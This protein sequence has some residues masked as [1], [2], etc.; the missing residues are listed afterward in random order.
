M[1][2]GAWTSSAFNTYTTSTRG[3]DSTTYAF[4]SN[5]NVQETFK[6]RHLHPDM[7]PRNVVRECLDTAEH[8]NTVPVILA[9]DVTGSMGKA[10]TEVSRKLG[11]IMEA[12]YASGK[13]PDVEFCVMAIGDLYCDRAPVQISQFESDI[14]IAEHLDKIWF[15]GG[16]GG[17]AFESYT[18]AW[19]MGLDHC[20]LDCWKRGRR[21]IIITMGDEQMNPYLQKDELH[22]FIGDS[23]QDDVETK[24]LYEQ[25]CERF[26]VHHISVD[27]PASSYSRYNAWNG[28]IDK[29]WSLLGENYHVS[30]I[31]KLQD[32]I[33]GIVTGRVDAENAVNQ[34][35]GLNEI[36][37]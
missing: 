28:A 5:L 36:S 8:P 9:L 25:V 16:G 15:E 30:T 12:I 22:E 20:K 10:A 11:L 2:G 34:G 1:G 4:C 26:D 3:M 32:T 24:D 13:V 17:N 7:D 18:A 33:V 27:D 29:S 19:Y 37:W 31:D 6:A 14:R 23:T 35:T 21:G